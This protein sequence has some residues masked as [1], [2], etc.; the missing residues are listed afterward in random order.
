MEWVDIGILLVFA[1]SYFSF[2]SIEMP[3]P[4]TNMCHC[5]NGETYYVVLLL[6]GLFTVRPLL[7]WV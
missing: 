3:S 1:D 7:N 6:C 4:G 5:L 2:M